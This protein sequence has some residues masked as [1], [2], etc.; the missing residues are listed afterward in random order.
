[1]LQKAMENEVHKVVTASTRVGDDRHAHNILTFFA[2][3]LTNGPIE[4]L[5]NA[6][7]GLIKEAYG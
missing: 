4:D 5:N 7:Q 6:L 1:M 3:R 2:H